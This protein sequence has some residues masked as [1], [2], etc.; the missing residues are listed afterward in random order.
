MP[1]AQ[2]TPFT[3]HPRDGKGKRWDVRWRDDA[4]RQRHKAFDRKADAE[5]FLAHVTADL[6]RG[7]YFDPRAGRVS[8]K[9][10]AEQCRAAQVHRATT[11]AQV[12]THLAPTV[13]SDR[14]RRSAWS[15]TLS[16]GCEGPCMCA[17]SSC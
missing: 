6:A 10:Y 15:L 1:G 12:E 2:P 5:R 9:T 17:S 8:F 7:A 13:L 11:A 4:S 3:N 16:T 14:V